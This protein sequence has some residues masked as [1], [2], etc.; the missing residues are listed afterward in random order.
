M[1]SSP[2]SFGGGAIHVVPTGACAVAVPVGTPCPSTFGGTITTA[3]AVLP[4][5]VL[6]WNNVVFPQGAT[7]SCTAAVPCS[8][9]TVDPNLKYPY[10][11]N[12]NVG[13]QHAFTNNLSLDLSYVG[14]HGDRLS[15]RRDLNQIDPASG[16]RPYAA[17]FPYLQFIDQ[18]Q[19]FARSNYHS[20]QATLTQRFSRGVA[21]KTGYT[22]G[23]GLDDGS[24]NRFA[25]TPQ[26]GRH[27]ELEYASSDSDVR[28]RLTITGSYDIPGIKRFGQL[29][30]GWKL[31]T[32]VNLQ[33]AQ[34]WNIQDGG[35]D[36]SGTGERVDRWNFYGNPQDFSGSGGSGLPYCDFSNYITKGIA[37]VNCYRQSIVSGIYTNLPASLAQQ[38][39]AVA[40]DLS[41]LAQGGCYVSG[42]SVMVPPKQGTFG[43]MGR[44]IFRDTGF[45]NVD[46]IRKLL[47]GFLP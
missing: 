31:N 9:V 47:S 42:K 15:G 36:F 20:L 5:S 2:Q 37:G 13:I 7:F 11:V 8:I 16:V 38:C 21:F 25:R 23:H 29:L 24:R 43:T 19:N 28:H 33:T 45:K 41:T 6:D 4:G 44:N 12:W 14:N 30:D 22:Y 1:Q 39:L 10:A 17:K 34:P 32:I 40:P 35:N 27:P 46:F 26:D 3:N 18:T